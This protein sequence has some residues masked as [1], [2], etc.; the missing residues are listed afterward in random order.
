MSKKADNWVLP[1]LQQAAR[2]LA[3]AMELSSYE[4]VTL[5]PMQHDPR[6]ARLQIKPAI[7]AGLSRSRLPAMTLRVARGAEQPTAEPGVIWVTSHADRSLKQQLRRERVNFI[8]LRG[9]MHIQMPGLWIDRTRVTHIE[10]QNRAFGVAASVDPFGDRA[11]RVA[12]VLL[13]AR[14]REFGQTSATHTWWGIRALAEVAHVDRTTTSEVVRRLGELGLVDAHREGRAIKARLLEPARLLDKWSARYDWTANARLGL[15]VPAGDLRRLLP[16]LSQTLNEK[17]GVR[18]ALG[19]HAGAACYAP[20]A[21]W[22][23]VHV[24]VHARDVSELISLAT[25]LE[26]E[27]AREPEQASVVLMAPKYRRA[28]WDDIRQV[29]GYPVVSLVQ[30]ILDLWGY[31]LR[32]REQ[33]EHLIDHYPKLAHNLP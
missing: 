6:T 21:V 18:W 32:G 24:Y 30:L 13:D 14:L 16:R 9:S 19:L 7:E 3:A 5:R 10:R 22:D 28:V 1:E 11:S 23:R 31:P 27:R 12:R 15:H 26:Y 20:H 33:A 25:K 8:D 4:Q 2:L 29:D 17:L